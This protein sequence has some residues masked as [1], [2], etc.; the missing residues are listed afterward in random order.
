MDTLDLH[1]HS[2]AVAYC[3]VQCALTDRIKQSRD[4]A[5]GIAVGRDLHSSSSHKSLGGSV[6]GFLRNDF[7][8][9]FHDDAKGGS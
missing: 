8:I 7:G 4:A 3:A 1:G 5:L 9:I 2:V 6:R